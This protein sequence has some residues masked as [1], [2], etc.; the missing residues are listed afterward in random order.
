MVI[1]DIQVKCHGADRAGEVVSVWTDGRE[2]LRD[3]ISLGLVDARDRFM[4]KLIA[5]C[6]GLA[7]HSTAL[8][9]RLQELADSLAWPEPKPLESA[10][11]PPPFP[12]GVFTGD[13]ANFIV[14]LA[15][16]Y[17]TPVDLPAAL[18]LGVVSA[19]LMQRINL[20][21]SEDWIEEP[22][23]WC[24]VVQ[25]S[26]ARKS[27]VLAALL[28]PV[29]TWEQ[30]EGKRQ[31]SSLAEAREERRVK[32]ARLEFLRRDLAR[33][34][35]GTEGR[36]HRTLKELSANLATTRLPAEPVLV[37]SD[38][39]PE[40]LAKFLEASG[41]RALIASAEADALDVILGRY[42]EGQANLGLMLKSYA[43]ES[44]RIRR[45]T[46]SC[47]DLARPL[48]AV[49]VTAQPAAVVELLGHRQARGRGFFARMLV[50]APRDFVGYRSLD[51]TPLAPGLAR[52]YATAITRLLA[53]PTPQGGP[54]TAP[55]SADAT[56][57][58]RAFR[59]SHEARL[60]PDGD[61]ARCREWAAKEVGCRVR[62]RDA[63]RAPASAVSG[64]TPDDRRLAGTLRR[65]LVG[66][67]PA[68]LDSA[69]G[70]VDAHGARCLSGLPA[71]RHERA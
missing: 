4:A 71:G 5:T 33:G 32:E 29:R 43:A 64:S 3:T 20:R 30:E 55:L 8:R 61:L 40:A 66:P 12:T 58:L 46:S 38:A 1:A 10:S 9:A 22:V 34:K 70:A 52:A 18:A 37:V 56:E 15:E 14:G 53:W 42:S 7:P 39:T 49:A 57:L 6:P 23:L 59:A 21:V 62:R 63:A 28:K 17:Q 24:L 11:V 31:A 67:P 65:K 69:R 45:K 41:E 16:T 27:P 68:R 47:L 54:R 13:V 19:T 25:D 36:D 51:A 2:L 48:I 50:V 44:D 26:G 35:S 60:R